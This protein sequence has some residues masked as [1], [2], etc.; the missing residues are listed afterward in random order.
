MRD[1]G[2]ATAIVGKWHLGHEPQFDYYKVLPGQG[3]YFDPTFHEK[4]KGVYP[5]NVVGSTGHSTD[6]ITDAGLEWL[7]S[8]DRSKPFFFCLQYKA[9]HDD[10]E[11]APRYENYLADVNIP[12]PDSLLGAGNHGSIA[13]R[14][15]N[16]ELTPF[17][18]SSVG[19]RNAF[20]RQTSILGL[21]ETTLTGDA[22]TREAY[23]RYLKMYLR[24]VKG[25]DDNLKRVFDYLRAEGLMDNTVICYTGDQGMWLGEH[26]Y[27][28]KRW[29]YEESMRMPMLVRYPPTIKAG[30]TSQALINNTDFAPTLLDFAGVK[31]PDAMHGRSFRTILETGK[32]PDDW[33]TATYYRYWMHL[34]HHWNP[35]HFGLRTNRYKLIFFY[36][37]QP[38]GKGVQTPPAWEFYDLE[39]DPHEM[40]NVYDDPSHAAT[41]ADLKAELRRLRERYDETDAGYPGVQAIIDAH[42]DTTAA[43]KAE[44]VRVSHQAKAAFERLPAGRTEDVRPPKR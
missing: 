44:A 36:G 5:Q 21:N 2:Y 26:D 32:T 31:A 33:R 29:M 19:N 40:N 13:T 17:L 42:W 9:P 24:C 15:H 8:R 7:R 11:Y 22:L 34:A 3:K 37:N 39:K 27:I 30:G 14:G 35:A 12:E 10:F 41:I 23:Q 43:S 20:R 28:D 25:I 4:G 6:V 18:A 1:A 16:G 38:D